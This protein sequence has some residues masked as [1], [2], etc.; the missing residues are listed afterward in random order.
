LSVFYLFAE[1]VGGGIYYGA[2]N[3]RNMHHQLTLPAYEMNGS[4]L[5]PIR[6]ASLR[7]AGRTS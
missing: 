4:A 6:D 3:M 1:G 2:R 5:P 7:C